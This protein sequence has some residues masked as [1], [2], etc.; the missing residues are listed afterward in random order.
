MSAFI[1]NAS[2]NIKAIHRATLPRNIKTEDALFDAL[3]VALRFPD[4]FGKNWN[5][6]AECVRDLSWLSPGDVILSHGDLPLAGNRASL[7]IYL[8]LL[9]DA[10]GNWDTR[11]SNLIYTSSEKPEAKGDRELLVK[12]KFSV[13]FPPNVESSVRDI[14]P[15]LGA[16]QQSRA[17][18]C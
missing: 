4:Y 17:A 2:S 12:R 15:D 18:D 14:V 16:S 13:I 7:S 1:F 9:S 10:V 5:A 6:L 8:S 3:S 11:G